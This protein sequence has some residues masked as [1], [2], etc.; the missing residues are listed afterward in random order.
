MPGLFFPRA[1]YSGGQTSTPPSNYLR[2]EPM[3]ASYPRAVFA[4]GHQVRQEWL[5]L[6]RS[7]V[8]RLKSSGRSDR[9]RFRESVPAHARDRSSACRPERA[10]VTA[11]RPRRTACDSPESKEYFFL[12]ASDWRRCPSAPFPCKAATRG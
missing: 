8:P 5:K 7:R 1:L 6:L 3:F 4:D 9:Y 12:E 10:S 11:G 2:G